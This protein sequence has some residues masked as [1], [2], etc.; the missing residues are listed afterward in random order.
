MPSINCRCGERLC[1]GEIPCPIEW[2]MIS[3]QDYDAYTG[4]V[5]AEVLY[6]AMRSMLQ[7]PKCD[8]LW[9]FWN[10]FENEPVAYSLERE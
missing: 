4:M 6:A 2:L 5:D 8:R 9:V 3:D 1:Y 10:G 7:C